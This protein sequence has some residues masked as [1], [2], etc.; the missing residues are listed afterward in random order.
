MVL[1]QDVLL[2]CE[3]IHKCGQGPV[4]HFEERISAWVLLRAAEH[5]MLENM[6]DSGAIHWGCAEL[7]TEGQER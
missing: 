6:G 2:T 5:G 1:I 7:Y 4:E 3:G